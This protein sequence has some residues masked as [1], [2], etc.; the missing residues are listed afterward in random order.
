VGVE[1]VASDRY[2]AICAKNRARFLE[3]FSEG[4]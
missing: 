2:I 4:G 3:I 1:A